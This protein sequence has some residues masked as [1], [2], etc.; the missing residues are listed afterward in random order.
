MIAVQEAVSN[1]SMWFLP[2]GTSEKE[3]DLFI[4]KLEVCY[5]KLVGQPA[6]L[7]IDDSAGF[8]QAQ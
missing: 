5:L 1:V 6:S 3:V 4:E 2:Q 7:P 8:E